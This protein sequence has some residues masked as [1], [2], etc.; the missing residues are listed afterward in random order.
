MESM[1][2]HADRSSRYRFDH[3]NTYSDGMSGNVT[4]VDSE[5]GR[6]ESQ[7]W[8]VYSVISSQHA[9]REEAIRKLEASE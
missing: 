9:A 8:T 5:T 3:D 4:I 1:V 6:S 7:Y 2:D